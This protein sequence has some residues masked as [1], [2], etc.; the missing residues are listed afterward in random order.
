MAIP[1]ITLPAGKIY[2][3]P[4]GTTPVESANYYL[5]QT[6]SADIEV[7]VT[8]EERWA[9]T[10]NGLALDEVFV[11]GTETIVTVRCLESRDA[12]MGMGLMADAATVSGVTTVQPRASLLTGGRYALWHIPNVAVGRARTFHVRKAL[13]LPNGPI[14][15][16][17]GAGGETLQVVELRFRVLHA[18]PA[19]TLVEIAG[20]ERIAG[21]FGAS[22]PAASAPVPHDP[23]HWCGCSDAAPAPTPSGCLGDAIF[24]PACWSDIDESVAWS[25]GMLA[26]D[27]LGFIASVPAVGTWML[28]VQP[29]ALLIDFTLADPQFMAIDIYDSDN[30]LLGTSGYVTYDV[31]VFT[32]SIPLSYPAPGSMIGSILLLL[33]AYSHSTITRIYYECA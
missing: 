30:N 20:S 9:G 24:S 23:R 15:L 12:V 4:V 14:R 19:W 5:G 33:S 25:G 8:T 27:N 21:S 22:W 10:E 29:A 26:I 6:D 3:A 28:G 16:K 31:G 18:S 13:A 32:V 1:S 2:V 7:R 17:R 11:T